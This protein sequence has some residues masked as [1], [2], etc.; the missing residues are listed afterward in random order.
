MAAILP[1]LLV[2]AHGVL[3]HHLRSAGVAGRAV[4]ATAL[5]RIR[6]LLCE[7]DQL[8]QRAALVRAQIRQA[9]HD[10]ETHVDPALRILRQRFG[11]K[12]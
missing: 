11:G 2:L 9:L 3:A 1:H 7:L 12:S 10:H 6:E 5:E 8:E 4:N